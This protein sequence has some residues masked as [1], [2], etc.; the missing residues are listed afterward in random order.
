MISL[1]RCPGLCGSQLSHHE[2]LLMSVDPSDPDLCNKQHP[3]RNDTAN[4]INKIGLAGVQTC[5]GR[6]GVISQDS[7]SF[8][9]RK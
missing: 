1:G 4:A 6:A 8:E 5:S 9:V 2:R 7:W 3:A